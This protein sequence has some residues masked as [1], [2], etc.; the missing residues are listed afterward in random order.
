V[1]HFE[2]NAEVT[3]SLTKGPGGLDGAITVSGA[4]GGLFP[5]GLHLD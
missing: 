2:P 1:C 5:Y 3:L 4:R